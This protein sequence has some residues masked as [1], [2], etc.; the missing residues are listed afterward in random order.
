MKHAVI[1]AHP[2]PDSLAATVARTYAET[3][4]S[5]GENVV[6]RD[7]YALGFDPCLKAQEIPGAKGFEAAP[8]VAAE[9]ALLSDI[10]VFTFVY[11]LWFNAPPAILKGYVDRVFSMGFGYLPVFGGTE[12]GLDGRQLMSF[13]S[14][15]A[16]DAWVAST[17]ALDALGQV[18]DGHLA[19]VCGLTVIDHVHFGGMV[20]GITEEA[21]EDT[22]DAV[23]MAARRHFGPPE[24]ADPGGLGKTT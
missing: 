3:L 23:R 18:F 13:T 4:R 7:L 16:P 15:G 8:D 1:I 2:N 21:F 20:P 17:G 11:P 24:S 19:A 22:L 10:Q 14:S 6:I 12:P 9:R 5:L